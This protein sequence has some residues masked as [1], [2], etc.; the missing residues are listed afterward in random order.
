MM[1]FVSSTFTDTH[2]E[3]NILLENVLPDLRD[4]ARPY[5]IEINFV[6]MRWGVRNE[7]TLDHMTW[8]A[9][10]RELE[11]C[12]NESVGIFFLSLQ[13]M[14]YGYMPLPRTIEAR[15]FEDRIAECQQQV[16]GGE[17]DK[18]E[19]AELRALA[20]E[21]YQLDHNSVPLVY[22]LA[23]LDDLHD[24]QFW[25]IASPKLRGLFESL[26]FDSSFKGGI[27]GR[28]VTEYEVRAAVEGLGQDEAVRSIRWIYREFEGGVSLE[29]DPK[30][31]LFDAH[32]PQIRSKLEGMKTWMEGLLEGSGNIKR[33]KLNVDDYLAQNEA[34]KVRETSYFFLF[35]CLIGCVVVCLLICL[36]AY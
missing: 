7:N 11:R 13:S 16:L 2:A 18:D 29:Q 8:I 22:K 23:N 20:T 4:I 24:E 36:M 12:R 21:W 33:F 17:M 35:I 27:I 10:R 32:D 25:K 31:R 6:D 9:C 5:G 28:S 30:Q 14:K 1:A 3:R 34:C 19:F 15:V 26:E